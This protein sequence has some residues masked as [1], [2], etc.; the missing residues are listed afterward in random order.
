MKLNIILKVSILLVTKPFQTTETW[1]NLTKDRKKIWKT[2]KCKN[3][4]E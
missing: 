2:S 3:S 4:G 1:G